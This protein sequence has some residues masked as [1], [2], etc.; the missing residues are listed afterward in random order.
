[1][2]K[3]APGNGE[4][5]RAAAA[6]AA[7]SKGEPWEKRAL[8][9]WLAWADEGPAEAPP[10]RDAGSASASSAWWAAGRLLRGRVAAG[11]AGGS[12][13]QARQRCCLSRLCLDSHR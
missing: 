1:M 3:G 13:G 5:R 6:E 12:E 8:A 10:S 4:A 9:M 2:P 11:G 7:P